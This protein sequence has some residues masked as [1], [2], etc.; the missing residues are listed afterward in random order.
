MTAK[1]ARRGDIRIGISGWRYAPWRGRFYPKDLAQRREL[2]Y[3][4][5]QFPSIELN[6]SFYSL[7]RPESYAAWYEQTPPGFVFAVKGGRY[8]THMLRLREVEQPLAAFFAQGL[9]NLRE[10]LGPLLWQLPPT[11]RF[12]EDTLE[13][14]LALL[15][16]STGEALKLARHRPAHMV[17]KVRLAIDA[18]R[19]LRHA[20]EVR[21]DSFR[22]PAFIK[23]LRR[24]NVAGV[25]ADTAGRWPYFEDL[26]A[27]FAYLRLHGDK[28]LYASGYT[29]GALQAWAHRIDTWSRGKQIDGAQ[30]LSDAP[31]TPRSSR[32][33][34]CYFDNDIK[35]RAPADAHSLSGRLGLDWQP[36]ERA[37]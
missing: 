25:F 11:M 1:T 31:P 23:L 29:P 30:L 35:V 37:A 18:D 32:D 4:S 19:P 24:Y 15:P 27:D 12:D 16:R 20:L 9:F 17:G 36:A 22:D 28:E 14:F 10:K 21:H 34:Y 33:V 26:T 8:I 5:A 6:G 3:A 7:Q 2:E 13:R